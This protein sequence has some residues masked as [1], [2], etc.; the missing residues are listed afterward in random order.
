MN[1]VRSISGLGRLILCG[2]TESGNTWIAFA[3]CDNPSQKT[4]GREFNSK[5]VA[6]YYSGQKV[7]NP[8]TNLLPV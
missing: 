7:V 1:T 5:V 8:N 4:F 2:K 6:F 3:R